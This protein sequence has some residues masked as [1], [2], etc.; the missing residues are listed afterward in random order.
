MTSGYSPKGEIEIDSLMIYICV[1]LILLLRPISK[2]LN[3]ANNDNQEKFNESFDE[4][5]IELIDK[6][7]SWFI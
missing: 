5:L 7:F 2:M 1:V 3:A 4:L 6:I